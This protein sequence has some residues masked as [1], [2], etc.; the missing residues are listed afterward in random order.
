MRNTLVLIITILAFNQVFGQEKITGFG[1]LQIGMSIDSIPELQNAKLI[2]THE[3]YMDEVYGDQSTRVFELDPDTT[4]EAY[5]FASFDPR[6]REFYVGV[7]NLTPTIQI[8]KVEMKFFNNKLYSIKIEDLKLKD[9]LVTKYGDGTLTSETKDHT[10]QNG[11][12]AKFVKTDR[13]YTRT[14]A[15]GNPSY[16]C[17]FVTMLWYNDKGKENGLAYGLLEDK[18]YEDEIRAANKAVKERMRQRELQSKKAAIDGF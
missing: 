8:E 11:Y 3:Q 14:W 18:S 7:F 9:L 17:Y 10:F 4:K 12:G 6:V 2:R 16:T 1:R 5:G 13:T 15:T